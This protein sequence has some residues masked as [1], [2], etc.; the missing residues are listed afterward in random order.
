MDIVV[1]IPKSEYANDDIET[2]EYLDKREE[3]TQFWTLNRTPK[4]IN[5][6]DRVYF[7]KNKKVDSSMKIIDIQIDSETNCDITNRLWK[8]NCQLFLDD[9]KI[10]NL[11]IEV[12]GFQGFRYKW[13][14]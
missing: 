5:I 8:G 10:E 3:Y 1:T 4:N 9:L 14:K 12:K 2:Q 13:W 7:I 6:G 11:N